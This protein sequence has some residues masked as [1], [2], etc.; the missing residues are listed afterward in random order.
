LFSGS[1]VV[2]YTRD[3]EADRALF[4]D[5]FGMPWVDAGEGWLILALPPAEV[6]FHPAESNDQHQLFLLYDQLGAAIERLRASGVE[7]AP[8]V[9]EHWG[10]RTT[11]PLPGGGRLGLYQPKHPS[12]TP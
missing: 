7:C 12:P 1:H 8:P 3:A 4:R 2:I 11:F 9:E 5:V 10:V 6:A